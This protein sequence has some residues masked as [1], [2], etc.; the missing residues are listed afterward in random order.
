M[1]FISFI[2]ASLIL[3]S[4]RQ[5][6]E[7]VKEATKNLK[8]G[9][10]K[11]GKKFFE[12][13]EI[14]Y[15]TNAIDEG[16][17]EKLYDNQS[18]SVLDSLKMGVILGEIPTT[19]SDLA[20]IDQ[21]VKIGYQKFSIDKSKFRKVDAIF[22][23]KIKNEGVV[24]A[25]IYVYRDILIFKKKNKVVG[26]AKICFGCNALHITGTKAHTQNFGENGDYEKLAKLLGK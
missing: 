2:A 12:Y 5:K 20:F 7:T 15:Y 26:I 19:I 13:D 21:L 4:C 1:K 6:T 10:T 8:S 17:I 23:E 3:L 9:N 22:V 11:I 18:K 14:E 24:S 16:N 25:C